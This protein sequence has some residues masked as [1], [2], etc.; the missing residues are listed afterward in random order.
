[1]ATNQYNQHGTIARFSPVS[2]Y[3]SSNCGGEYED[4][5]TTTLTDTYISTCTHIHR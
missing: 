4:T 5:K 1:L 2:V 3:V